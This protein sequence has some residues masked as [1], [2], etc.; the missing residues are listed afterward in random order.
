MDFRK[1]EL[2]KYYP[3]IKW[4]TPPILDNIL[5][6]WRNW[7]DA[8]TWML[9]H[10]LVKEKYGQQRANE[11]L[12]EWWNKLPIVSVQRDFRSFDKAFIA[13]AKENKFFDALFGGVIGTV[14]KVGGQAVKTAGA[15]V[16]S[17]GNIVESAGDALK[18]LSKHI[19]KI[20][21]G[22]V[23]TLIIIYFFVK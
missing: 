13:Y 2:E 3:D 15:V 7:W 11:V 12:I 19:I 1:N 9:W 18:F 16:E 17:A 23:I 6:P 20:L 21:I 8:K 22:V 4:N 10:K 5:I 14:A